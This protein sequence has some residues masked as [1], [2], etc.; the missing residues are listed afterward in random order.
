[1][2]WSFF[3]A[4]AGYLLKG[5]FAFPGGHLP[6]SGHVVPED[7]AGVGVAASV[8]PAV[9][10]WI[11]EKLLAAGIRNVRLDFT[12]GDAEGP[13]ERLLRRLIDADFRIVLHLLQPADAARQM[14]APE[15]G[16]LWRKFV[17]DTLNCF[18]KSVAMIEVCS[19]INRKRWAGYSIEGF[20]SAWEIAWREVRARGLQLAGPSITDFEPP[21][22]VGVLSLL[23]KR[24][25][26]PD[27]HTDNLFAERATEPERY[28]HK[29]LGHRLA[30][31]LKM[32]LV[33]K[34]RLLQRIG[35]DFG[36]PRMFS[37]AAFWTLPR[38][39]RRLPAGEQ[40]QADYL[41]RYMVLAAA[42]GALEGAWW[43]PLICHREGLVD[44]GDMPYPTLERITHYASVSDSLAKLMPR[45]SFFALKAFNVHVPGSRY[46][47]CLVGGRGLEVHAFSSG[48]G[49]IFHVA[50]TTNGHAA[51]LIDVYEHELLSCA[52]FH[53]RDGLRLVDEPTLITESPIYIDW[54]VRRDTSIKVK[55]KAGLLPDVA[56]DVHA[57][58]YLLYF[59]DAQWQGIVSG[60]N[61]EEARFLLSK[62]YPSSLQVEPESV[63]RHAR[64]AIWMM[65]DPRCEMKRLVVKKPV[66][67]HFHKRLL[68]RFK[69]SKGLRSWSGTCELLR[70]GIGAAAPVAWFEKISDTTLKENFYLSELV[71]ADFSVREMADKFAKGGTD[72]FGMDELSAWKKLSD[73][74]LLMHG[75]GIH[76]RDLSGGNLLI[77]HDNEREVQ[78][79][80]I[81]TGRLHAYEQPLA[82]SKRISDLVR[83]CNKMSAAGRDQ[84]MSCYLA[85][86]GRKFGLK[87]RLQFSIYDLKVILKRRFGRKFIKRFVSGNK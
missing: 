55:E 70:R 69:P 68:D 61:A 33:K 83:I 26:L 77:S 6:P 46:E 79:T 23:R 72:F 63:L 24:G 34:A 82:I 8:D 2:S 35:A 50:W 18:G 28:D 22:N 30:G 1:M 84:F 73:F 38:I 3:R 9:D 60:K 52:V 87:A 36:V 48:D 43:G 64:N 54:Q 44:D 62:I 7:F 11:I 80:L 17:V 40:K 81:D 59:R 13:A 16:E 15:A 45:P 74:L 5:R 19:T 78:F 49:N 14:P 29:V 67:M 27:I 20:L 4:I 25:L 47:A 76:F 21:W 58:N 66:K 53:S 32:N 86:L 71:A 85:K 31:F 41:T 37:P 51:A 57:G 42:S 10:D 39:E 65:P 75:R 12:Y 56:V